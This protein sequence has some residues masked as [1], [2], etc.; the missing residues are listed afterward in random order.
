MMHTY[1]S[2]GIQMLNT[3]ISEVHEFEILEIIA[4]P[5]DAIAD[6][7]SKAADDRATRY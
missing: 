4:N 6:F 7:S 3:P 1:H 5:I 2:S